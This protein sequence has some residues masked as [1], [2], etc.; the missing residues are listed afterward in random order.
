MAPYCVV[1]IHYEMRKTSQSMPITL[2][3]PH[4]NR[5]CRLTENPNKVALPF[6]TPQTLHRTVNT[7]SFHHSAKN[8]TSQPPLTPPCTQ[9]NIHSWTQTHNSSDTPRHST[10]QYTVIPSLSQEH[11]QPAPTIPQTSL[12]HSTSQYTVIPSLSQ[13]HNQPAPTHPTMHPT[14]HPLMDPNTQFLSH[15]SDTPPVNTVIPSLSQE[16]NQPA[17]TIPQPPLRH[18][19]SQ[20]TVIPSLSQEHN[21]PAPTHPTMHPT[22]HTLMDPNTQFL[23]HPSDT[24]PVNTLSFHHSAKNT[25]SQPPLTPP[26]TQPNTH[27]WTQTHNSSATPQ[28]LHQSTLSFHHSVKNTTSQPPLNPPCT[29]PYTDSQTQPYNTSATP[30]TSNQTPTHGPNHAMPQTPLRYP[31]T[32]PT[33]HILMDP[34]IQCLRHPS[35]TPPHIQPNTYSWTQSHNASATPT[36]IQPN[37]YSRMC[38]QLPNIAY[39]QLHQMGQGQHPISMG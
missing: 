2:N 36:H 18:S 35:D 28:T 24:P 9:P 13:E 33:K 29:Q 19:T 11:N 37:T 22:K 30:H 12:R 5:K 16:H 6:Q 34:T 23:S 26:C 15:P 21:Q 17:P 10:S 8:T 3:G 1:Q 14:K 4:S 27:S 20:Y 39:C 7:L 38:W 31:T 32:H 25:T